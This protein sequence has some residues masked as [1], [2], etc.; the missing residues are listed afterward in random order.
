MPAPPALP[1]AF[2]FAAAA[3]SRAVHGGVTPFARA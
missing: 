1:A 2:R 3:S